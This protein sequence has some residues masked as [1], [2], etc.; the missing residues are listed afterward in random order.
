M[1]DHW[2]EAMNESEK[3]LVEL[4][5]RA[6]MPSVCR[7][8]LGP[9]EEALEEVVRLRAENAGLHAQ[10]EGQQR[11]LA[12]VMAELTEARARVAAL[13]EENASL[14]ASFE[15]AMKLVHPEKLFAEIQRMVTVVLDEGRSG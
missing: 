4:R 14:R 1:S 10:H 6:G 15:D 11:A 5:V 3:R 8:R 9:V 13:E 12:K 7:H 2:D